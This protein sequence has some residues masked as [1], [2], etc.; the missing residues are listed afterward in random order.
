[1]SDAK[2][3]PVYDRVGVLAKQGDPEY[4]T[5][6]IGAYHDEANKVVSVVLPDYTLVDLPTESI[7]RNN[8]TGRLDFVSGD[9]AFCI[10]EF[11]ED[12][13]KWLSQYKTLLPLDALESLATLEGEPVASRTRL[14]PDRL[15]AYASDDS[16]YILGVS[17]TTTDGE[18]TRLNGEWVLADADDNTY[19]NMIAISI[20]PLKGQ[21]FLEFYDANYVSVTDAEKYELVEDESEAPSTPSE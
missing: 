3:T 5:S 18:W 6:I 4:T 12:D 19:E 17:Y 11:R 21:E 15:T 7:T 14:S 16:V 2:G 10:R 13:G 20:A 8:N 9:A 1:M